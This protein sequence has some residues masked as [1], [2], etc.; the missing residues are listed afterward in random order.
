MAEL[1]VQEYKYKDFFVYELDFGTLAAGAAATGQINIQADSDFIWH[2]AAQLTDIAG[3]AITEDS[4][5]IPL[6]TVLLTD[7]GAG[8]Q[9]MNSAVP[10]GNL[11]GTAGLP[12]I[13]PRQRIFRSNS[14][15]NI[16]VQ[17]YSDATTYSLRLSL[18]GEKAFW[19]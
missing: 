5:P 3:A 8:R 19:M 2:K 16:Q 12:F 11:F 1:N 13:L 4:R 9:L 6:V 14:L 18:I 17:N 10:I 7:S 15:I